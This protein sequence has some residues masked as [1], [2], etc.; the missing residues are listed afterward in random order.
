MINH[1]KIHDKI[2]Q[3][4]KKRQVF[5]MEQKRIADYMALRKYIKQNQ[6]YDE[7]KKNVILK[8]IFNLLIKTKEKIKITIDSLFFAG[9]YFGRKIW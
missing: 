9:W 4:L 7:S 3:K 2:R 5:L 1:K 6:K 8:S